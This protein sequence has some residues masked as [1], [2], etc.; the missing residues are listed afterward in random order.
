MI[1]V[2]V[3]PVMA[4]DP[5]IKATVR[6]HLLSVSSGDVGDKTSIKIPGVHANSPRPEP[7]VHK[8]HNKHGPFLATNG[9]CAEQEP[10]L[11]YHQDT[12]NEENERLQWQPLSA[13]DKAKG[14]PKFEAYMMTG[15]H[16]LNISRMPQT[17]T[18]VPKQQKKSHCTTQ[19]EK[20]IEL[21][22]NQ[23][24]TKIPYNGA[25]G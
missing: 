25:L 14:Q 3:V 10:L 7:A 4:F 6:K 8:V 13:N 19:T 2:T 12:R 17:T 22:A 15:E 18:I 1:L 9:S 23:T 5:K 21:A 20:A 11:D 16:I 24:A